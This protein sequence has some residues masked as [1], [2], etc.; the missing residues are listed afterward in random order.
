MRGR[1]GFNVLLNPWLSLG[2]HVDH[3]APYLALHLPGRL[4]LIGWGVGGLDDQADI[5]FDDQ[6]ALVREIAAW[7]RHIDRLDEI[8]GA[9]DTM[10]RRNPL[11]D[12]SLALEREFLSREERP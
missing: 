4:V 1:F 11:W 9:R 5:L 6:D 10:P 8:P 3:R 7:L 12:A 2:L